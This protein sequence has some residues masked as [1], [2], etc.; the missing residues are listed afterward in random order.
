MGR[1]PVVRA[2]CRSALR[3]ALY[4]PREWPCSLA[5]GRCVDGFVLGL[6][7]WRRAHS[8]RSRRSKHRTWPADAAVSTY[9][10][11][12]CFRCGCGCQTASIAPSAFLRPLPWASPMGEGRS[13]KAR[14]GEGPRWLAKGDTSVRES[15]SSDR[16]KR[17]F[18]AQRDTFCA[19]SDRFARFSSGPCHRRLHPALARCRLHP[20]RPSAKARA[21]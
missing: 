4:G 21:R 1:S 2:Y 15:D 3:C 19:E 9:D 6:G 8:A 11:R 14:E 18:R 5:N 12:R 17:Q 10:H 20:A 16:P 13:P 7:G